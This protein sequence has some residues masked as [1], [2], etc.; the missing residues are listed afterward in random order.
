[1][2][3]TD[4]V[5]F[6]ASDYDVPVGTPVLAARAGVVAAIDQGF[7]AA[8]ADAAFADR[9]N[10]VQVLHDDG[11]W[12]LYL[13]IDTRSARVRIGERVAEGQVLALSGHNGQSTGPHLHFAVLANRDH[14]PV[15]LPVMITGP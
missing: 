8:G 6:H 14:Q 3:H 11:T 4:A 1:M 5:S 13:H 2:S 12:A 7:T 10:A 9:G 15:S